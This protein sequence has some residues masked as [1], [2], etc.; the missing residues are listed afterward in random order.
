MGS[1]HHLARGSLTLTAHT[2]HAID[3]LEFSVADLAAVKQLHGA[4][5]GWQFT[6]SGPGSCG[7][8]GEGREVGGCTVAGSVTRGGPW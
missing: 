6:D 2:H 3:S 4:A 8:Q 1:H 7:I 5:F